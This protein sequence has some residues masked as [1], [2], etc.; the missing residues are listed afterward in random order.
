[1]G[2]PFAA[3]ADYHIAVPAAI[4]VALITAAATLVVGLLNLRIQRSG[5]QWQR[6]HAT[7]QIDLMQSGQ[8]TDR[9]M[10]A[11][12][13]LGSGSSEVRV[14]AIFALER[15]A[16]ESPR[17]RP[18]IVN[19]LAVF[20][21]NRL[22]ESDVREGEYV[23]VLAQRVPDAQAALT[24]LCRSPLSDDRRDWP[25]I[26]GLDLTRTDLRRANL[27]NA[28]LRRAN[29]WRSHLEG[30]DLYEA[31][32][33]DSILGDANFNSFEPSN[34]AFQRGADLR[35]TNL[36]GTQLKNARYLDVALTEGAVSD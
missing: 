19:T 3:S 1:M 30:A 2:L 7:K 21:R 23:Q 15:I 17:D 9:F 16:G 4:T 18:H 32:L 20:V 10:R 33:R 8:I 12:E 14:G 31:D 26:G 28:N 11:V 27:K 22:P 6:D 5:L 29:L 34:P 25:E 36:S 13:H 35:Q 24:A